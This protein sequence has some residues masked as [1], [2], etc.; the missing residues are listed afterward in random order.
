VSR[1]SEITSH[2]PRIWPIV[3][4]SIDEQLIHRAWI[5]R[6]VRQPGTTLGA[7]NYQLQTWGPYLCR[8]G[9]PDGSRSREPDR[10]TED[11][12]RHLA[13][14]SDVRPLEE[15][16]VLV[17]AP[18]LPTVPINAVFGEMPGMNQLPPPIQ[19]PSTSTQGDVNAA[20]FRV[21]SVSEPRDAHWLAEGEMALWACEIRTPQEA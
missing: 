1:V 17:F 3:S 20:R 12:H 6:Q 21:A 4:E 16:Y 14:R 15:D 13:V 18:F 5:Q 9:T 11:Q 10:W 7:P 19:F 2:Q 8:L